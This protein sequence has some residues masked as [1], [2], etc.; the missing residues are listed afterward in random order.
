V[1]NGAR[2]YADT[3]ADPDGAV[4]TVD[5]NG[6]DFAFALGY[7]GKRREEDSGSWFYNSRYSSPVLQFTQRDKA[8]YLDSPN[9]YLFLDSNPVNRLDP[10]GYAAADQY[11]PNTA[12]LA[13]LQQ[14]MTPQ[15]IAALGI[16]TLSAIIAMQQAAD[17]DLPQKIARALENALR[18]RPCDMDPCDYLKIIL[19]NYKKEA[20]SHRRELDTHIRKLQQYRRDPLSMDNEGR[21]RAAI[22]SGR[23]IQIMGVFMGRLQN[24]TKQVHAWQR[25]VNYFEGLVDEINKEIGKV[26]NK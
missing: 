7:Q 24:L 9:L 1:L 3:V 26:C 10:M 2:S 20:R 13:M 6:S 5:G 19:K 21:L 12:I 23:G 22:Q 15:Q 8:G 16:G 11:D 18:A 14:G 4:F 25:Q 17:F